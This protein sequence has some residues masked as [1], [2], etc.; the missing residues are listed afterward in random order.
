MCK[1]F[2]CLVEP[3]KNV[4]WTFGVDSHS[5]LQESAKLKDSTA[6]PKFWR[7]HGGEKGKEL[8]KISKEELGA[9]KKGRSGS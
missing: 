2:S 9:G 3:N 6:D 7:L 1:A 4:I 8:F 5:S